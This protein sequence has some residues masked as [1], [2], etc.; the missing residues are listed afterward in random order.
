MVYCMLIRKLTRVHNMLNIL[1]S[2]HLFTHCID[3]YIYIY[4]SVMCVCGCMY[5]CINTCM[6]ATQIHYVCAFT[7]Y[8]YIYNICIPQPCRRQ[9]IYVCILFLHHVYQEDGFRVGIFMVSTRAV[10]STY[11]RARD[12]TRFTAY[13]IYAIYKL[14]LRHMRRTEYINVCWNCAHC[15]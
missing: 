4:I 12:D 5:I 9:K 10:Y 15:A 13:K 6:Y 7:S 2:V 14:Y 3:M 8:M 1:H 11:M